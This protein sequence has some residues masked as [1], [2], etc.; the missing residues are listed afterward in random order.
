MALPLNNDFEEAPS[1]GTTI[2]TGNSGGGP[3]SS[4]AFDATAIGT[5]ATLQFSSTQA[6]HGTYSMACATG[7]T[8]TTATAEW[9]TSMG[10]QTTVY[11]RI[12][13]YVTASPGNSDAIVRFQNSGTFGLGLQLST[14]RQ[15]VVQDAAF[16]FIH[17]LTSVIPTGQWVRWEWQIAFS[18]SVGQVTVNY[19]ANADSSTATES[20]TSAASQN[21]GASANQLLLGWN[22]N[23]ANQATIYM[24]SVNVNG[25]GFPGP[26]LSTNL[27]MPNIL[28]QSVNRATTWLWLRI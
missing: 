8:S 6:A 9:T 1:S 22:A 26:A 27:P 3:G 10:T 2:T 17:T 16:T 7:T 28:L 21:F 5:G 20:Y 23:H 13:L 4:N 15:I 24:D 19:Y 11:G 12:Y 25:T 14:A 18:A